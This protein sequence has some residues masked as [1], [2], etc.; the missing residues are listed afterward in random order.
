MENDRE[1]AIVEFN[2]RGSKIFQQLYDQFSQS[3]QTLNRDQDDNVFQ[4]QANKHISTLDRRLN[5]LATELIGK[6]RVLNRTDSLNPVFTD[7]IKIM[8][9]EFHQ[10][11]RLF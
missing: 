5:W 3:V 4:L 1:K 8:L 6:Y 10:K 11:I 7:R 9:R 2:N